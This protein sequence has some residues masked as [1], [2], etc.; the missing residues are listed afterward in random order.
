LPTSHY[1]DLVEKE[2]QFK[3]SIAMP[4]HNE[5]NTVA[6]AIRDVLS[7]KLPEPYEL[8]IVDD[9]SDDATPQLIRSFTDTHII[10]HRHPQNLGK[11]AAVLTAAALA[12]GSHIVIFDADCE[13][14]A[15][16]MA[17]LCEPV[18]SKVADIIFGV[19]MFG[20]NTV[21]QSY[22]YAM[23][24][25]VTTFVANVM[26]DAYLSDL[27][28]CLKLVPLRLFRGLTLTR[29]GFGLD[30]E[31]TAE[32]LRRGYRPFEVP[33]SYVSRSRAEGKKLTWKDGLG[34]L[35]VLG[36]V[37]LR[38]RQGLELAPVPSASAKVAAHVSN[39][40][41]QLHLV[42]TQTDYDAAQPEAARE[43]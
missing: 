28:S 31:I 24:N 1:I 39:D 7:A 42:H 37:R 9:G 6:A 2:R 25:R 27:H 43:C 13:Y 30:S 12:S 29:T 34:C 32:L 15:S 16:D 22:R 8:I 35:A 14:R 33:V 10:S 26:F 17:R 36:T 18:I 19:R 23:G 3:L 21:Y 4:V 41:S 38:G 40:R 5:A 20:M 11:G